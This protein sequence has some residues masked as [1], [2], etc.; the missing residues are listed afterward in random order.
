MAGMEL[1]RGESRNAR[2]GLTTSFRSSGFHVLEPYT[3]AKSVTDAELPSTS[4][5]GQPS[6]GS[7]LRSHGAQVQAQTSRVWTGHIQADN[8]GFKLLKKAGWSVGMGLGADERGR[9]DPI[10]PVMPK[11]TRGLGFDSQA[12]QRQQQQ[13]QEQQN[14]QGQHQGRK[15]SAAEAR[16]GGGELVASIVQEELAAETLD[17]KIARHR[18][19][20]RWVGQKRT[21]L[22]ARANTGL[23]SYVTPHKPS[24]ST[25]PSLPLS[26]SLSSTHPPPSF[27]RLGPTLFPPCSGVPCTGT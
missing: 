16:R 13:K 21:I 19:I 15:R 7:H 5:R 9:R 24:I 12:A 10:E 1:D 18:H 26:S 27:P 25:L 22:D 23:A 2:S 3:S 11:G 8:V 6:S 14:S 17:Q 20:M 4:G